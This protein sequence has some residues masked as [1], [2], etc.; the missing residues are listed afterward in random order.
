MRVD[1]VEI[2]PRLALVMEGWDP[3]LAVLMVEVVDLV[4]W[5][6]QVG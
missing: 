2:E 3:R 1:S 6:L 4:F 5:L